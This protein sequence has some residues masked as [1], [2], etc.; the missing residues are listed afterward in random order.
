MK[1]ETKSEILR[2]V[3][4]IGIGFFLLYPVIFMFFASFKESN[5][6]FASKSIFPETWRVE[7][8][9]NGWKSGAT[10]SVTF[11]DFFRNTF[12]LVIPVVAATVE[13]DFSS[14]ELCDG[15]GVLDPL[16]VPGKYGDYHSPVYAV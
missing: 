11:T 14:K 13:P 10:G 5:E 12:F 15:C 7:N 9:V 2:H 3:I 16:L 8:F 6:I 1:K 4:L